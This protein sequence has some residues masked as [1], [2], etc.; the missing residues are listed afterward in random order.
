MTRLPGAEYRG[1]DLDGFMSRSEI[2]AFFEQY[3][4]RFKLPVRFGV[5]VTA[6]EQDHDG[7]PRTFCVSNCMHAAHHINQSFESFRFKEARCD[8]TAVSTRAYDRHRRISRNSADALKQHVHRRR[9]PADAH[10]MW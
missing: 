5:H 3:V 9:A 10:P 1:T 6:I 4:E 8:R 7:K 2:V